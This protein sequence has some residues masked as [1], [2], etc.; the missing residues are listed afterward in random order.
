MSHEVMWSCGLYSSVHMQ[1]GVS[2]A[3][4]WTSDMRTI[5]LTALASASHPRLPWLVH[6]AQIP[7]QPSITLGFSLN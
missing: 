1:A 7:G 5:H 2:N 6:L 4:A 3:R